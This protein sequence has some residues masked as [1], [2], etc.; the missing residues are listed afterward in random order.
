MTEKTWIVY[1]H[2]NKV[3]GKS[4]IGI[5][6]QE[7]NLRWR[8]GTGYS[9][10]DQLIAKAIEKYGWDNFEH[11]ILEQNLSLAVANEREQYWISY[12]HTYINDPECNGYNM[13]LGGEG[14]LGHICSEETR[15][16]IRQKATGRLHTEET[17]KKISAA[18]TGEKNPFF[19]RKHSEETKAK[20]LKSRAGY[21]HSEETKKK[22]SD[23][24]KGR[25]VSEETC[26]LL[27][28]RLKGKKRSEESKQRIREAHRKTNANRTKEE[29]EA[30]NK[31]LSEASTSKRKV[32]CIETGEV[33][34]S[35]KEAAIKYNFSPATLCNC[36]AGRCKTVKKLHW[37]E[38]D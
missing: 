10:E 27:S 23:S 3:N 5:T 30:L 31:K 26:K 4:Y 35:L 15:D 32:M 21:T 18:I 37:K 6:C 19:K 24:C 17:K 9:K 38:I 12:Y 1:R 16:K 14:T 34:N 8:N 22:I 28:E 13:T 11:I 7:P 2:I 29:R 33:F 36:L 20:I 25:Q